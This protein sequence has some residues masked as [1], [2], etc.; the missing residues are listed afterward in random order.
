M[1]RSPQGNPGPGV[2]YRTGAIGSREGAR[3]SVREN[4]LLAPLHNGTPNPTPEAGC[5]KPLGHLKG[6]R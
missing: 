1:G 6:Y 3:R 2:T 5:L 4:D